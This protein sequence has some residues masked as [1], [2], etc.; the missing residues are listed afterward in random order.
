[1]VDRE[2]RGQD[3]LCTNVR[4]LV[5]PGTVA[6]REEGAVRSCRHLD[7]VH[8][9]PR[10][11]RREQVLVPVLDPFDRP[12]EQP[13]RERDQYI[14]GVEL[15]AD[16]EAAADVDFQEANV[17]DREREH[18]RERR[19]VEVLD[20][21]R[22]PQGQPVEGGV[23]LG[24]EAAR[25]QRCRRQPVDDEPLGDDDVRSREHRLDV[26]VLDGH[27]FD[28]VRA[29]RGVQRHGGLSRR[30]LEDRRQLLDVG[31][32]ELR[33]VLGDIRIGRDDQGHRLADIS[34]PVACQRRLEDG[35][36]P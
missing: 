8:L 17:P 1:M 13:S 10:V 11:V 23:V 31:E 36:R 22:A 15:A 19:P 18:P 25:L 28:E 32:D 34:N 27:A 16:T 20:L 24:D 14:L 6:E 21:R 3:A 7:L 5:A 35:V 26:A 12:P 9:L 29:E 33:S 30:Q 2:Q 4:A